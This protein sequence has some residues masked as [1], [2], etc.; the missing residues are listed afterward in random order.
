MAT[1]KNPTI[2][3][4]ALELRCQWGDH[5]NDRCASLNTLFAVFGVASKCGR[6]ADNSAFN[7][8]PYKMWLEDIAYDNGVRDVDLHIPLQEMPQ[9]LAAAEMSKNGLT[10]PTSRRISMTPNARRALLNYFDEKFE[11][12]SK[13]DNF[14]M[15]AHPR[16]VRRYRSQ[17]NRHKAA[18]TTVINEVSDG[19]RG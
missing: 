19:F 11:L 9:S 3:E 17:I 13:I 1:A 5:E 18:I 6:I 12:L 14:L 4:K 2:G 7:N 16:D 15:S 10:R 8:N